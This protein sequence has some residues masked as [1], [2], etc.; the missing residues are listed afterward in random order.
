M[1][2]FNEIKAL[3]HHQL[4]DLFN[5]EMQLIQTLPMITSE[6][7]SRSLQE[8]SVNY[9]KKT[10]IHKKRLSR[11][12][13][14]LDIKIEGET[15]EAIKGLIDE[16]KV[17]ITESTSGHDRDSA[18]IADAQSMVHYKI[19]CYETAKQFAKG[20]SGNTNIELIQQALDEEK[21]VNQQLNNIAK[22]HRS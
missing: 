18:I 9:L 11:I 6:T 4:R 7:S 13:N 22:R 15:C 19:S 5:A 12:S 10:K 3:Y 14:N 8:A 17:S 2:K 1:L 20:F 21:E 16:T